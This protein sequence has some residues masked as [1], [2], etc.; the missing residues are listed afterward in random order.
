MKEANE[1]ELDEKVGK[2]YNF[3]NS[4]KG[5]CGKTTFSI[6]LAK[7]LL[8]IDQKVQELAN[9]R[10]KKELSGED[11]TQINTDQLRPKKNVEYGKCLILDMD[12]QGTSMDGLFWGAIRSENNT[13]TFKDADIRKYL[14]AAI[15][16]DGPIEEY[17]V[18]NQLNDRV[19][20]DVVFADTDVKEKEK[21]RILPKM[22]YSPVVQYNIFRGGLYKFLK[23]FEEREYKHFIFDM[24]PNSDGFSGAA[25]E[26]VMNNIEKETGNLLDTYKIRKKEDIVNLFY[27]TG[28]DPGQVRETIKEIQEQFVNR[29]KFYFDNLFIVMND[30]IP[31]EG[32]R[33]TMIERNSGAVS[34]YFNNMIESLK[35]TQAEYEKVYLMYLNPNLEYSA[36][37]MEGKGLN[38]LCEVFKNP[39]DTGKSINIDTYIPIMPYKKM[40]DFHSNFEFTIADYNKEENLIWLKKRMLEPKS[41]ETK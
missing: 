40:A 5:G 14:N 30:N 35:L 23:K 17:I 4:I 8:T 15:R 12:F 39:T 10:N 38:N 27:V 21:L 34:Q 9:I 11:D 24:P 3:V 1:K 31:V 25:L 7:Y 41:K 33:D 18:H 28:M 36:Y 6:F 20:L 26:C 37:C 22:G 16:E 29:D 13:V 19:T 2:T 32:N